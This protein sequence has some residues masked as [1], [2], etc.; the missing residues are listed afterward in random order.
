EIAGH[1][2]FSGA[3]VTGADADGV[4]LFA[5]GLKARSASLDE[6]FTASGAVHLTS[7]EIAGHLSFSGAKVTGADA[8]GVALFAQGLK[9]RS[10]FLDEG[11]T[12]SGAV[13]LAGAEIAG[14]LH[15]SGAELAGSDAN[16]LA[17]FADGLKAS[18]DVVL[19][20][21]FTASGVV[22][23]LGAEI[24]GRLNLRG[25]RLTAANIDGVALV[26]D[27]LKASDHVAFD[28]GFSAA[29]A[30]RLPD[31][32]IAGHLLLSGAEVTGADADGVALVADGMKASGAFLDAGFTA[33]GAVHL[34][35]AEIAGQLSLRGARITRPDADGVA[36]LADRLKA[37]GA[38]LDEGFAA[39]GAVRLPEAEI[40]G[41]MDLSGAELAG[42][43][44]NGLALFADGLK[45]SR[46]VVLSPGFT[47]S[48]VVQL[49]GAEIIGRLNL[50]GARL[51]GANTDGV[52]LVAEGLKAGG[53]Y[54]DSG[55]T[56]FGAVLLPGAEVA[57]QLSLRGARIT[58]AG[59]NGVALY[60]D[61][62]KANDLVALDQG[63]SV[64]GTVALNGARI[65]GSLFIGGELSGRPALLAAGM[66]VSHDL[67]WQ[68]EQPVADLVDLERTSA[69]RLVDDWSL[70]MAHWP[71]EGRLKLEG[72]TYE[73]FGNDASATWENRL[74]WVRRSHVID[75]SG[76]PVSFASQ[77][78]EQLA[79]VYRR[80]GQEKEGQAIAIARRNDLRRYGAL[81]RWRRMSNWLLDKTIKHGYQPLRAVGMLAAVYLLVLLAAWGAQHHD[82][83][84]VPAKPTTNLS[85]APTAQHCTNN[86]PCFYAAG[87]A[88]DVVIP[89][90][91][92]HQ[93]EHWRVNSNAP[94]GWSWT[95]GTWIATGLGW[96]LSTLAVAGYTG[97][98]RRD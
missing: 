65:D 88:V 24:I 47:A 36:L 95:V 61:G 83:A 50:R 23:L 73:G 48:G 69:H 1:L 18:R 70:P 32:E 39:S 55:F 92:V 91:N 29:G 26:A 35:G 79:R 84:I 58:G 66:R 81:G 41:S 3:K 4:A 52:A 72:F 27:R 17:L 7:A 71:P 43:D 8:D 44:A 85:P 54:L 77:P 15:L 37:S 16:G 67:R 57:G 60:V 97:L 28:Q 74:D 10:T 53:V 13:H 19:S 49:L 6:G 68:P 98:I 31:A 20:P 82:A 38:F 11:F 34:A 30:V 40:T 94:W 22:Q 21:G 45:A 89:L 59:T 14:Q 64:V 5:Q 90:I 78:Y 62:L 25:A 80:S 9:A 2:S 86:Y 75:P 33:S 56:A 87:Y 96:A 93:A 46:D 51:T 76:K 42:S 12:A 63:F